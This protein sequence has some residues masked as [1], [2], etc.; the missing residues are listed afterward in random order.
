MPNQ[1]CLH[2]SHR[3]AYCQLTIRNVQVY[4]NFAI[5]I[6]RYRIIYIYIYMYIR[7]YDVMCT[8]ECGKHYNSVLQYGTLQ[9]DGIFTG[10]SS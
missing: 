6:F 8:A 3:Y 10:V 1:M 2:T 4:Y 9:W 7:V 5:H